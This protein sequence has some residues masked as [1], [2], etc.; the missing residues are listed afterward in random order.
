MSL[1]KRIFSSSQPTPAKIGEHS[2]KYGLI[3]IITLELLILGVILT[4]INIY[5]EFWFFTCLL[6]SATLI[7]ALNLY[8][9]K[10][11]YSILL[12]GHIINA[13][14]WVVIVMG[15]L[16]IGGV[17]TSYIG[18]F[19]VS[20]I[21]AATT[22]GLNGLITYSLL[23]ALTIILFISHYFTP[24]FVIPG[25]YL[26]LLNSMNH[27]FIFL[28]IFTTLYNL[29]H[30]NKL[31]E[32][33][34]KEQNFLLHSDKQKFH[35]LSHHDSLTNLPNRSFFH[36]HL[37]TLIEGTDTSEHS[38]T[39]Y[40]MD[41][42]GFK[43]INDKYGHE[44]GDLLLLQASKRLQSCFRERDFI[45]RLG[46]DEFTALIVHHDKD[47]IAQALIQRIEKEFQRPFIIK[48]MEIKC[49]I[50]VGKASYPLEAVNSELLMK[51]ADDAMYRNKKMKHRLKT[52][53]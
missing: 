2:R 28:L 38:I 26:S 51:L 25:A 15:N 45:A 31:F 48:N 14:C 43:K 3:H 29:L 52:K 8:L 40:F 13:L 49:T 17:A 6:F 12:C 23:S 11:N 47:D 4:S 39:L 46:G 30:E 36:H 50:S 42:D 22:I 34:L 32:N 27:I 20:P 21:I 35:Y 41:L 9:L 37:Q 10:K 18:W 16:W 33:L 53:S 24:I 44:V 19:Y 7:A 5:L 1:L